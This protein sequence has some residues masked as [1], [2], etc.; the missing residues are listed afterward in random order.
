LIPI[1]VPDVNVLLAL[2]DDRHPNHEAA[3]AW[4]DASPHQHWATCPITENGF[5]RISSGA[6]YAHTRLTPKE[7]ILVLDTFIQSTSPTHQFWEDGVALRDATLFHSSQ[8]SGSKQV[9]DIYLLGLCQ[10]NGGALVT[11]DQRITT[12]AI[13]SPRANLIHV[14]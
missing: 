5:I 4:F 6:K 8:I 7:A 11:F 13:V 9:T 3:N 12:A 2:L 1:A 10:Q 14:L